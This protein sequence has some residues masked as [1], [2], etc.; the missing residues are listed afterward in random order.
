M[1]IGIIYNFIFLIF[2]SISALMIAII[3]IPQKQDDVAS[4]RKNNKIFIFN[5][6][7]ML[8]MFFYFMAAFLSMFFIT[9]ASLI[10]I[11]I[12][13]SFIFSLMLFTRAI[14]NVALQTYVANLVEKW[15]FKNIIIISS[16]VITIAFLFLRLPHYIFAFIGIFL[17]AIYHMAVFITIEVKALQLELPIVTTL[18]MLRLSLA[19]GSLMCG[20]CGGFILKRLEQSNLPS[21]DLWLMCSLMSLLSLIAFTYFTAKHKT[22]NNHSLI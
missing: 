21:K 2:T 13:T 19:F 3:F 9:F 22:S 16:M 11:P 6:Q 1:E 15:Q 18:N 10:F 4:E 12:Y 8:Y 5:K 7:L 14:T 20:I 17:L